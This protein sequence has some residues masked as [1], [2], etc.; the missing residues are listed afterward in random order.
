MTLKKGEQP[1]GYIDYTVYPLEGVW[2]LNEE[3]RKNYNGKINKDD[4]VFKLM[5]R[6]P[7]FV[8]KNFFKKM[9]EFAKQKK[10]NVFLE[11]VFLK[12]SHPNLLHFLFFNSCYFL[13]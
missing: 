1:D 7:D 3:G 13:P 2:D 4:L 11:K 8:D 10:P 12:S 6:Q 9:L 5:I